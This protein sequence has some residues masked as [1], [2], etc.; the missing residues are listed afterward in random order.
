MPIVAILNI[1]NVLE[2]I[3]AW[4]ASVALWL[5]LIYEICKEIYPTEKPSIPLKALQ[6][7]ALRRRQQRDA[8]LP[9]RR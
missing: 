9:R 7:W 1:L 4:S 2:D 8:E 6:A 5:W 3:L